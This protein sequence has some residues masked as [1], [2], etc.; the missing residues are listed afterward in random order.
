MNRRDCRD[1]PSTG[2]LV[3]FHG[4][5]SDVAAT[6]GLMGVLAGEVHPRIGR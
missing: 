5:V 2:A 6:A 4:L 3:S 1:E